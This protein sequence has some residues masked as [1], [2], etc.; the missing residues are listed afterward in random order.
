V[1]ASSGTLSSGTVFG[2]TVA[3]GGAAGD[4]AV[5]AREAPSAVETMMSV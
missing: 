1:K 3:G 4:G 5:V 2:S